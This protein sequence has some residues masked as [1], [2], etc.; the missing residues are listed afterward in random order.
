MF[1]KKIR[2]VMVDKDIKLI[3]IASCTGQTKQAISNNLQRDTW[4]T[5]NLLKVCDALGCDVVFQ[6]RETKKIY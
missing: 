3:D 6:D 2:H 1:S 4:T 5:K